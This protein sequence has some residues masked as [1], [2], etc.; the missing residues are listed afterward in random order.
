VCAQRC[1]RSASPKSA[2]PSSGCSLCCAWQEGVWRW[3]VSLRAATSGEAM[4]LQLRSGT[5]RKIC[6]EGRG[7]LE[8]GMKDQPTLTSRSPG[9]RRP[10]LSGSSC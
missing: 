3:S 5:G 6:G 8:V 7:R 9:P 4:D 2:W 10:T 1:E